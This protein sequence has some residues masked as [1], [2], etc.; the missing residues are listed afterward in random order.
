VE[1]VELLAMVYAQPIGRQQ[2]FTEKVPIRDTASETLE[3]LHAEMEPAEYEA[4]HARGVATPFETAAKE[5]LR[6]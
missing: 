4:A 6:L 5:L 1:A 2:S 3:R